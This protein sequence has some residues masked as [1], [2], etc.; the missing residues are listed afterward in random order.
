MLLIAHQELLIAQR[1]CLTGR[2]VV[3]ECQ[4]ELFSHCFHASCTQWTFLEIDKMLQKLVNTFLILL[5]N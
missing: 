1:R 4:A 2:V 3:F 5:D